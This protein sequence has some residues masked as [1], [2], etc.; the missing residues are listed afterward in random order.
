MDESIAD[1]VQ[2]IRA[3]NNGVSGLEW[4]E[5][6]VTKTFVFEKVVEVDLSSSLKILDF[7]IVNSGDLK[8]F[9]EQL[10]KSGSEG[11]RCPWCQWIES[12]PGLAEVEWTAALHEAIAVELE[13]NPELSGPEAK[14]SNYRKGV[15]GHTFMGA[16]IPVNNFIVPVLHIVL[17]VVKDMWQ[18]LVAFVERSI[19]RKS[20]EYSVAMLTVRSVEEDISDL[21]AQLTT[22]DE[23]NEEEVKDLKIKLESELDVAERGRKRAHDLFIVN[24]E[25]TP[26][27]RRLLALL[28]SRRVI[29]NNQMSKAGELRKAVATAEKLHKKWRDETKPWQRKVDKLFDTVLKRFKVDRRAYHGR[30]FT[31]GASKTLMSQ[32]AEI[33]VAL[34]EAVQEYDSGLTAAEKLEAWPVGLDTINAKLDNF[35]DCFEVFES[36]NIIM[37]STKNASKADLEDFPKLVEKFTSLYLDLHTNEQGKS[38]GWT[39]KVHVLFAHAYLQLLRFGTLGRFSEEKIEQA[40][41]LVSRHM[42][43]FENVRSTEQRMESVDSRIPSARTRRS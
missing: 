14:Y 22:F 7:E 34:K 31:G 33:T 28:N 25:Q 13:N 30:S 17:G 9:A 19:E 3:G 36:V 12:T 11:S 21:G 38:L 26:L 41:Q 29:E 35:A 2:L 37:K 10:N 23:Q 40:H 8:W 20:P 43:V 1:K 24:I 39:P 5:E 32:F 4:E 18:S 42:K 15:K 16:S 27:L 6:G